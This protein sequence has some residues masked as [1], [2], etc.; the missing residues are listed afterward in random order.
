MTR[1]DAVA[2]LEK[3]MELDQGSLKGNEILAN[4]PAWDSM[5]IL[6]CI[7]VFHRRTGV[8]LDGDR[9]SRAR[10]VNELVSLVLAS[11]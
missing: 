9:V 7:E 10:N 4:M 5:T 2:E 8:V 1:Q 6:E 3:I 11:G